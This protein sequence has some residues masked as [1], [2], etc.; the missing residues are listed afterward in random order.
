MYSYDL[1]SGKDGM[2]T[3]LY[4]LLNAGYTDYTKIIS[5][6]PGEHFIAQNVERII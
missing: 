6:A 2:A 5:T 3:F 1:I 4:T